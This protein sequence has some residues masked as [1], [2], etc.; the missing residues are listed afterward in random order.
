MKKSTVLTMV[1]SAILVALATVLS[2][3]H[4]WKLPLGG[5]VTLLSM[6][7]ICVISLRHG[8][9]WGFGSAFVYS[10][11]QLLFGITMD[12]LLGWGLTPAMLIGCMV[13]DYI[14]AFTVLG[15]A[16]IFRTKSLGGILAGFS[17]AI[18]LRFVSHFLSGYVIFANLEQWSLF[19]QVFENH[20]ILYSIAY[21]GCYLLPELVFT[22]VAVVILTR[23]PFVR[24]KIFAP[25]N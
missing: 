21:N 19:G 3:I 11:I 6:L 10:A 17:I 9:K 20:P 16:G 14:A 7:P 13:F 4:V 23:I 12:G 2:L 5:S 18:A 1:E 22:L 24:R 15:I 8:L 25:Q